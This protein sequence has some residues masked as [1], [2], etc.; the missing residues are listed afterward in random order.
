MTKPKDLENL[1]EIAGLLLDSRLNAMRKLAQARNHNLALLK[2]LE[3]VEPDGEETIAEALARLRYAQWADKRR[4]AINI[5]L[6]AQTA[7]WMQARAD[8]ARAFGRADVLKK[9][10]CDKQNS[11]DRER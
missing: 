8:A 6:A 10:R 7:E 9:L 2:D 11:T 1:S 5:A 3:T 4:A